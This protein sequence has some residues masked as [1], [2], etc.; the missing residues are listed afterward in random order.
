MAEKG[1]QDS[2]F[3]EL[4]SMA[5]VIRKESEQEIPEVEYSTWVEHFNN[6]IDLYK[7]FMSSLS[8]FDKDNSLLFLR[9]FELQKH[10]FLLHFSVL[11][12][13]YHQSIRELRHILESAIQAYYI[14]REHPE[15]LMECKLEII[16]EI[17]KWVGGRLIDRTDLEHK[18]ELKALYSDLSKYVHSSYE[19]LRPTI[20]KGEIDYRVTFAFNKELF[21][22]CMEFTN[23]ALDVFFFVMLSLY[24]QIIPRI[25]EEQLLL[26]S[27]IEN[28]CELSVKFIQKGAEQESKS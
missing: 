10:L 9:F 5:Q 17:D 3:D 28:K 24:P 22:K 13:A 23:R 1:H 7:P 25:R 26:R 12:G 16:K 14:D 15:A 27:L 21:Y 11:S 19:E 4:I 8:E 20:E 18:K 6:W 2:L